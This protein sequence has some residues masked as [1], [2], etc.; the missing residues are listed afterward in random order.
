MSD[1]EKTKKVYVEMGVTLEDLGLA[2]ADLTFDEAVE[3]LKAADDHHQDW[4]FPLAIYEW[5]VERH[6]E[7]DLEKLQEECQRM[8]HC[9]R[10]EHHMDLWVHSSPH[11]KCIL[12]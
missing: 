6:R 3:V 4:E 11:K 10:S 7:W 2:L 12:R 1:V 5:V 9:V 8:G